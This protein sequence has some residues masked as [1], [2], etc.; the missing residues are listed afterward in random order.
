MVE[1][2]RP[3][4]SELYEALESVLD[5]HV[6]VSLRAMGMLQ[7]A[8]CDDEGRVQVKLCIPCMACPAISKIE[9]DIQ[10]AIGALEGVISI[11]IDQGWDTSWDRDSVSPDAR[12]IMRR[13]GILL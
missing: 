10:E 2:I 12:E 7:D 1:I 3:S 8:T 11:D 4:R 9:A 6:P 13:A 5:P